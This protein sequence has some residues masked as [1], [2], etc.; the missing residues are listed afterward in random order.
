VALKEGANK[1]GRQGTNGGE[2]KKIFWRALGLVKREKNSPQK[3][4]RKK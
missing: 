3:K 1:L 4:K 2:Q